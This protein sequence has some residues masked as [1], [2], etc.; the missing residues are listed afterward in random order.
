MAQSKS[1]TYISTYESHLE[2]SSQEKHDMRINQDP[3]AMSMIMKQLTD[4]YMHP[5]T[6]AVRET[7]SNA[8]DATRRSVRDGWGEIPPVVVDVSESTGG[9]F[10][11]SVTDRG[12]GMT[13]T[14]MLENFANYGNSTK[15][16]DF[17][18]VGSKGLGAKSPL[19]MT[20]MMNVVST[21]N[22]V[23][24]TMSLTK[25]RSG[26]HA[27]II[28]EEE[29]DADNGTTV[30]F[31][32]S[33]SGIKECVYVLTQYV[34]LSFDVPIVVTGDKVVISEDVRNKFDYLNIGVSPVTRDDNMKMWVNLNANSNLNS[35][36]Y[37]IGGFLYAPDRYN[38][39]MDHMHMNKIVGMKK[40]DDGTWAYCVKHEKFDLPFILCEITP[41]AV[42]FTT[43]RESIA[44]D[45]ALSQMNKDVKNM[46]F[47]QAVEP[48]TRIN[49]ATCA[50][51]VN[52]IAH[53]HGTD[54]SVVS[55]FYNIMREIF[56]LNYT[57]DADVVRKTYHDVYKGCDADG[58][59]LMETMLS[60]ISKG[61]M[62][63]FFAELS[64]DNTLLG[65]GVLYNS[66]RFNTYN[67]ID[68]AQHDT[69]GSTI[70][71]VRENAVTDDV[72]PF[73]VSSRQVGFLE[74]T[75]ATKNNTK[76]ITVVVRGDISRSAWNKVV[77]SRNPFC[78]QYA[79]QN[80]LDSRV[81]FRILVSDPNNHLT[82]DDVDFIVSGN[83]G[84]PHEIVDVT[85]DEFLEIAK[86]GERHKKNAP[87]KKPKEV[88]EVFV[89]KTIR[90]KQHDFEFTS[91]HGVTAGVNTIGRE[92]L[93][94][95]RNTVFI[96]D[97]DHQDGYTVLEKTLSNYHNM[98]NGGSVY[99]I[100]SKSLRASH[101][102]LLRQ[103]T[104][105][106]VYHGVKGAVE[107]PSCPKALRAFFADV[108]FDSATSYDGV[109]PETEEK[110][111][112]FVSAHLTTVYTP[113]GNKVFTTKKSFFAQY[114]EMLPH[115]VVGAL[116]PF[117]THKAEV[118]GYT[119][120]DDYS[121][122]CSAHTACAMAFA[123]FPEIRDIAM[124]AKKF[125]GT[126]QVMMDLFY[127]TLKV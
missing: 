63:A 59:Q 7:M 64:Q 52:T 37:C 122:V 42:N 125:G 97:G 36:Q 57:S 31:D 109:T 78:Q 124:K 119:L 94:D 35:F 25:E 41:G 46:I 50:R 1:E 13:K 62:G 21:K 22:G 45:S 72:C 123:D 96:S 48:A 58:K 80:G 49:V 9:D 114:D 76:V 44:L 38:Q 70:P 61:Y 73:F 104:A 17:D 91:C 102:P 69:R 71:V 81:V 85:C 105:H 107:Y 30:S 103:A 95:A 93:A 116:F 77:S 118:L 68:S 47:S 15:S 55:R 86:E 51:I 19:A 108:D 29:T 60:M 23:R 90:L 127:N 75:T 89:S 24:T 99:C 111:V 126:A 106:V 74:S 101:V 100:N 34:V 26:F 11:F 83:K 92:E 40:N 3:T 32:I 120:G 56:R 87:K 14:E 65:S 67:D 28:A 2:S 18:Q 121:G 53:D 39:S 54:S 98:C 4:V 33:R 115:Y 112:Q 5:V 79:R 16:Y 88:S 6:S 117:L 113:R 27:Y 12:V 8:I 66:I 43:S 20:T 10:L 82:R 110:I 84:F